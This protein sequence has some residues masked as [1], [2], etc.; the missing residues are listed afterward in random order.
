MNAP[1]LSDRLADIRAEFAERGLNAD[2]ACGHRPM[3]STPAST[4]P[5]PSRTEMIRQQECTPGAGQLG[6]KSWQ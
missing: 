5:P 6:S 1:D 3:R 2:S 4:R